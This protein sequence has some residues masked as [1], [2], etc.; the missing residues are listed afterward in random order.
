VNGEDTQG[1]RLRERNVLIS[2]LRNSGIQ[3]ERVLETMSRIPRERFVPDNVASHAYIDAPLPIGWGQ[4]ISQPRI[5]AQMTEALA[6]RGTE[7]VLEIGTGSGYQTAILAELCANV[8][9]IER[10]PTLARDAA[11]RLSALGVRNVFLHIADGTLGWVAEAPYD[12][13]IA[14]GSLPDVPE[15]LLEQLSRDGGTF[16]GPV[17]SREFQHL[18]IVRRCG[19]W[20]TRRTL[21]GCRFVPLIG[22]AGWPSGQPGKRQEDVD[23]D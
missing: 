19:V 4:T 6:L 2:R 14:T 5:V 15:P 1:D 8:I 22:K 11:E 18:V 10:H 7:T 16:I 17:G 9:S 12:A 20:Y 21:G 13:M 3:D 23:G